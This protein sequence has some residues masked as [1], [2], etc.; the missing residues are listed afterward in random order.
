[1]AGTYSSARMLKMPK[2]K[3]ITMPC[4]VKIKYG[5]I[6]RCCSFLAPWI[7]KQLIVNATSMKKNSMANL[8]VV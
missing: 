7:I 2:R 5:R 3:L 6:R 8:R 4:I 1:M